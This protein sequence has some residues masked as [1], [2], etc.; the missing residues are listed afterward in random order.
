MFAH[1]AS[2]VFPYRVSVEEH[3]GKVQAARPE[4]QGESGTDSEL[5]EETKNVREYSTTCGTFAYKIALR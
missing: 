4:I 2:L 5:P 3:K 1:I